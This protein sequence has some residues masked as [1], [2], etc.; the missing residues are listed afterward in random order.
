[1]EINL[2]VFGQI[3]DITGKTTWKVSG[4]K[5]TDELSHILAETYPSLQSMKY[6][7][8]VNKKIIQGNTELNNDD[9]VAILPP[10]S[11]G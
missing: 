6:S 3:A 11:G 7:I 8:A 5:N 4:V 10:F 2:L 1:M 9:T